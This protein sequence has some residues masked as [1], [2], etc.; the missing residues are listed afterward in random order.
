[1]KLQSS[2]TLKLAN[3]TLPSATR[4]TVVLAAWLAFCA[5]GMAPSAN[6]QAIIPFDAPGAGSSAGQGTFGFGITPAG[7]IVGEYIDAGSVAHGFVR[8]PDGA[9]TPFDVTGAGTGPGQGTVPESVNPS[10]A[11]TGLYIDAG[12]LGHG[13]VRS[14]DGTITSFDAPGAGMPSG[15]P[16][17]P[18]LIAFTGTQGSAINPAGAIA[19]QY[20]DTSGVFHGFLRSPDG[21]ITPYDAPGAATGTGQGTFT[22]FGAGINPAEE[23]GGGYADA[24]CTFHSTVRAKDGTF[25]PADVPGAGTGPS[26]GTDLA[27]INPVGTATGFYID[28][29][30]VLH[31]YV[32]T[33][34]G[35]F[36]FFDVTDVGT[37]PFQGTEPL[38][39]NVPGDVVGAYVD[40]NGVDHGFVRA[41]SG[42]ITK[43]DAPGAGTSTV[44]VLNN[45]A[46]A[47][48]GYFFDSN[49]VAH[50]FLRTQ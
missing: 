46:G 50:G 16:C 45:P 5:A 17:S 37:G 49:G 2:K 36:T 48:T 33:K 9:I 6:G 44:P 40:E 25:T 12:G 28:A 31:G 10:G 14:P 39:I 7:V 18:L 42:A 8:S 13:F 43:F 38:G 24:N 22:T 21:T 35:T 4:Q 26:Q 41:K 1:M 20:V 34:D 3:H 30:D 29:S 19:G 11:I 47:I 23:I 27:G 15:P 32:R